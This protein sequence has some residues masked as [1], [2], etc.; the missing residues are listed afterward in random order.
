MKFF[1]KKRYDRINE[2]QNSCGGGEGYPSLPPS[3][4]ITL[5]ECKIES[6]IIVHKK[7]LCKQG[8]L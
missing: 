6:N 7:I 8:Q 5:Y 1:I 2:M 3:T 4:Q